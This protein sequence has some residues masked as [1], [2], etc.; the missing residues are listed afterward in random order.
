LTLPWDID[1]RSA[2]GS[3]AGVLTMPTLR[4]SLNPLDERVFFESQLYLLVLSFWR[5]GPA[6]PSPVF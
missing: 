6:N 2:G 4:I 5:K 1:H 3:T